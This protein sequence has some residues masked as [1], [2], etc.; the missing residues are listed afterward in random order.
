M[1]SSRLSC[2]TPLVF[3]SAYILL[4]EFLTLNVLVFGKLEIKETDQFQ[5]PLSIYCT[6]DDVIQSVH[7]N[8]FSILLILWLIK[9]S[10]L[11][12]LQKK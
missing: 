11:T 5:L 9:C 6:D 4:L 8:H 12:F 2:L 7:F 3:S 1:S 10:L